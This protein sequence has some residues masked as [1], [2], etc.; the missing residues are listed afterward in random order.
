MA[1]EHLTGSHQP[2]IEPETLRTLKGEIMNTWSQ[3]PPELRAMIALMFLD[4]IMDSEWFSGLQEANDAFWQMVN[5]YATPEI[6]TDQSGENLDPRHFYAAYVFDWAD[7]R[8][9]DI[10]MLLKQAHQFGYPVRCWWLSQVMNLQGSPDR[11]IVCVHHPS[12]TENAGM[13]LYDSLTNQQ[14]TWDDLDAAAM[15]EYCTFGKPVSV[16][17]DIRLPGD[18]PLFG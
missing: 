12:S 16:I 11:L 7:T 9:D 13:D 2:T 4:A 5:E 1:K 6:L 10:T 17:E 14:V 18:Q 3:L 15:E 8:V